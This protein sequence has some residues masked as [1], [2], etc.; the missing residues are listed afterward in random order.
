MKDFLRFTLIGALAWAGS[1]GSEAYT[2]LQMQRF[3]SAVLHAPD[4][5]KSYQWQVSTDGSAYMS[6][7]GEMADSMAFT[8]YA[9][10][11][12]R[13]CGNKEG[14]GR[15]NIDTFKVSFDDINYYRKAGWDLPASHGYVEVDGKN[16]GGISIPAGTL[17]DAQSTY[18]R[19]GKTVNT[20][21]VLTNWTNNKAHA[22]WY[23][24]QGAGTY[25][26]KLL[27]TLTSQAA[28]YFKLEVYD[29]NDD[30]KPI[31]E[32]YICTRGTGQ[33][34]T[35]DAISV[36]TTRK[37]YYRYDLRCISGYR[38]I[39]NIKAWR[40]LCGENVEV[41]TPANLS[42]PSVHLW[43]DT[44]DKTAPASHANDWCYEEVTIPEFSDISGTYCMAIGFTG[45]YMG[46]QNNGDR[47]DAIFSIWDN[48]DT[49]THPDLANYRKAGAVDASS[50][51]KVNR[52]GN[53]GTGAQIFY[54]DANWTPGKFVQFISNSQPE[55]VKYT[56][57]SSKG[58]DSSFVQKNTLVSTWI[59]VGDGKG[60][61]YMA[62]VRKPGDEVPNFTGWYSFLENYNGLGNPLRK[63]YYKNCYAHD[64]NTGKWYHFN[65]AGFSNTDGGSSVGA[66]TDYGQGRDTEDSN[67]FFMQSGAFLG[68]VRKATTVPLRTDNTPVD[69]INMKALEAR[70][71]LAKSNEAKLL[72]EANTLEKGKY[73]KTGWKMVDFSTE[74]TSGEG[75]NGR[76]A[77]IIDGDDATYWHSA[78]QSGTSSFPHHFVV[79]M[80]EKQPV[81]GFQFILSGG[82]NRHMKSIEIYGSDDNSTWHKILVTDEAP[83]KEKYYLSLD[84]VVA[85]RY[86]KLVILNGW[87]TEVHTRI[88]EIN[89]THPVTTGIASAA[90]NGTA[91]LTVLQSSANSLELVVPENAGKM[92]AELIGLSGSCLW[93]NTSS[94]KREGEKIQ[95]PL[96]NIGKGDVC[97]VRCTV[98]GKVYSSKVKTE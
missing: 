40:Y 25:D 19:E 48:G 70:V 69:T 36:K 51:V 2:V 56:V 81:N 3:E 44:T 52:F 95:I 22:V 7:P 91:D 5:Y 32:S 42:S 46:I 53:E 61:Q 4:G 47:H 64:R 38:S 26:V 59:N 83:D 63:G 1:V 35:V 93:S 55:E 49:D 84:S 16:G 75:S 68:C 18:K 77:E 45:G 6:I 98:D 78:W 71:E 87:T 31:A 13:L 82:T 37:A 66:R 54:H 27:M 43:W 72:E 73:D 88:N 94:G 10:S 17:I 86:F 30:E 9:P 21:A 14:G 76:A 85:I 92:T 50:F 29:P 58:E 89:V 39:Q 34:E 15:E 41:Y 33:Q 65:K 20:D 28:V 96:N 23:A 8:A 97:I 12:Y 62:T 67:C 60:W 90:V 57:K 80:L 24:N 79:D 74:E 11:Y